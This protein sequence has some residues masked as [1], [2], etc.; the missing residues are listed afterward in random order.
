MSD[1]W[2]LN[3]IPPSNSIFIP[4]VYDLSLFFLSSLS[5]LNSRLSKKVKKHRIFNISI[6]LSNNSLI[7]K[8]FDLKLNFNKNEGEIYACTKKR[9]QMEI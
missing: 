4:F 7:Q 3:I 9:L 2:H 5:F 1:L 8:F 6:T